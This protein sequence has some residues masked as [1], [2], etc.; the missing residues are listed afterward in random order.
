MHTVP[1]LMEDI[2]VPQY[3][4]FPAS[5]KQNIWIGDDGVITNVHFDGID[6]I[7]CVLKGKKNFT[8]IP[9]HRFMEMYP[10][11]SP[12]FEKSMVSNELTHVSYLPSIPY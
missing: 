9:R 6:G 11:D 5:V 1:V 7:L 10:H 8:L 2:R 4:L 12:A 3:F